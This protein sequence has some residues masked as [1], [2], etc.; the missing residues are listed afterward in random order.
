MNAATSSPNTPEERRDFRHDVTNGIIAMLEKGVA[1][2]Q[3]PWEA[4]PSMPMNPTTG[5]AYRG[6]N[7]IQ[8]MASAMEAGYTDPRW[9]TYRQAAAEGWQVRAGE[10]GTRIEFWDR[11]PSKA[12]DG[13]EKPEKQE[14]EADG[15]R[16]RLIHR[17]YTVF[18]AS[19]IA[20]IPPL[21]P[22]SRAEFEIAQTGEQILEKSG[23]K[24]FHDQHDRAFYN[25]L[26]DAVHLPPRAA[27]KDATGYYGTALHELAHWTGHTSRLNRAT[28]N[29]STGFGDANY[30][31]EELRAEMASLFLAAEKGIP[32]DP[33][34]HA[35]YV[36]AWI[37]AL[38][39]DKNEIFRAAHDAAA[40]TDFLLAFERDKTLS[41]ENKP[42]A[43]KRAE[44][45]R[46]GL[47]EAAALANRTL[48]A[49]VRTFAADRE[50]GLYRGPIVAETA[51][52]LLQQVSAR[53]VIA[54]EKS[55][56]TDAPAVGANVAIAYSLELGQV[57][58]NHQRVRQPEM[59]RTR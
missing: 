45:A 9:L 10:R 56:L 27:F 42:A 15:E 46:E 30:A 4:T 22:K 48:G 7:A 19:Q 43:L 31:R 23:A 39:H 35:A 55:S 17:I 52:Q 33:D 36:G 57:R 18:N 11:T 24:L 12:S 53:S 1:P 28:L 54:H 3:K 5:R 38:S 29:E 51:D 21:E 47:E 41:Y 58:D 14:K 49:G 25:R 16:T 20:G 50:S 34:R 40:A 6:G 8:L 2:W 44:S 59:A 37:Q 32:H 13:T 26:E